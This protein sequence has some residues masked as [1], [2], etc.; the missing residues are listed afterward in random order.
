MLKSL[1]NKVAGLAGLQTPTQ[2][3]YC[4][5][6]AKFLRT[7][8]FIERVRW[9]LLQISYKKKLLRTFLQT[10]IERIV[11]VV[12]FNQVAGLELASL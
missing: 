4:K 5:Y 12:F 7:A 8:F 9:L 10:S 1:F 11:I 3:F 6:I 2:V